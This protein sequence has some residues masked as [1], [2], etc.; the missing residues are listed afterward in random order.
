MNVQGLDDQVSDFRF[1][2]LW[3]RTSGHRAYVRT[4]GF[5]N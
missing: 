5:R 4:L 1:E 3:I 2:G